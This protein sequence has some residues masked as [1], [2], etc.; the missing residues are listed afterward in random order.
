MPFPSFPVLE[1][2]DGM[3]LGHIASP[4]GRLAGLRSGREA[5]ARLHD[6]ARACPKLKSAGYTEERNSS[7]ILALKRNPDG[8]LDSWTEYEG[9]YME[10]LRKSEKHIYYV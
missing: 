1:T 8:S 7:Q 6:I 5:I 3:R 4:D 10:H 2:L 9:F